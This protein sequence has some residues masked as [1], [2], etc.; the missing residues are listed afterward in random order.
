MTIRGPFGSAGVMERVVSTE[1]PVEAVPPGE[2]FGKLSHANYRTLAGLP[3]SREATNAESLGS[4]RTRSKACHWTR[5][6]STR[7]QRN[8]ELLAQTG[9][10]GRADRDY[11]T[12]GRSRDPTAGDQSLRKCRPELPGQV[13]AA[14]APIEAGPAQ[15]SLAARR[16]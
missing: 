11:A 4:R 16:Q 9:D 3:M 1:P 14:L 6:S 7:F 2:G 8:P 15:R 5:E 13:R 10:T 12:L